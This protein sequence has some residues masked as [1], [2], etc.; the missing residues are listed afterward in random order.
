MLFLPRGKVRLHTSCSNGLEEE[1]ADRVLLVDSPDPSKTQSTVGTVLSIYT[2]PRQ[3][4]LRIGV[5]A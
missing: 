5:T 2:A 3:P 1:A 4:G